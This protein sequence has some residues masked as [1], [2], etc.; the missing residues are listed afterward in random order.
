MKLKS[1]IYI[2]KDASNK[3]SLLAGRTG[4]LPNLLCRIGFCLSLNELVPPNPT[5][6]VQDKDGRE[7]NR[8]T[9]TGEWDLLFIT[10]LRQRMYKDGFDLENDFEQQFTAHLG[11]GIIL[12]YDRVKNLNELGRLFKQVSPV[13]LT[14]SREV[15]REEIDLESEAL[16]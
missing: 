4:L 11:R 10:L 5:L 8:F 7:F 14:N 9:L 1:K 12:L 16:I 6:Y 15:D 13:E 2:S 3:L